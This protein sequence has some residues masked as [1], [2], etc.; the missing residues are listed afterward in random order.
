MP[1]RSAKQIPL[2]AIIIA[3]LLGNLMMIRYWWGHNS[4]GGIILDSYSRGYFAFLILTIIAIVAWGILLIWHKQILAFTAKPTVQRVLFSLIVLSG[5]GIIV[6]S[7]QGFLAS[8]TEFLGMNWGFFALVLLYTHE[9]NP[10]HQGYILGFILL[11]V[12]LIS[13]PII[14]M[15][16]IGRPFS[17]DEAIWADFA[18]SY[19]REGAL[20]YTMA[21][22]LPYII[23]PGVG[24]I[25]ALHGEL[26]WFFDFDIRVS[27]VFQLAIYVLGILS[28]G[29][30]S[31]QLYGKWAGI[32]VMVMAIV[33]SPFLLVFDYRPDHFLILPQALAFFCAVSA[34]QSTD[35]RQG[36]LWNFLAGLL[37]TLSLQF[38]AAGLAYAIGM[39][40]FY[41]AEFVLSTIREKRIT[42]DSLQTLI[43]YGIGAGIGTLI[44]YFANILPVGGLDVYLSALIDDRFTTQRGFNYLF[45]SS[46]LDTVLLWSSLLF[47][48][49]R[50]NSDD[51]RYL[52]LLAFTV[53]GIY[54]IDTQGYVYPYLALFLVPMS[55][56]ISNGFPKRKVWLLAVLVVALIPQTLNWADWRL[57]NQVFRTQSIAPHSI[58]LVGREILARV[59]LDDDTVIV[60]THELVWVMP[61]NQ[62]LHAIASE[63]AMPK[64]MD[65]TPLGVWEL[66]QPEIYIEIPTRA[67]TPEG[68]STYLEQEGFIV[69]Q[70]FSPAGID[71][72]IHR[73]ECPIENTE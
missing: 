52:T 31:K 15:T 68:L 13:I 25:H 58:E 45:R 39:S 11:S 21:N 69:C 38:H 40:L 28:L 3:G 70:E 53:L 65:I 43:A 4:T 23:T 29:L 55:A 35:K 41:L 24:W 37:I 18:A 14:L 72:I 57:L 20:S 7:G 9:D 62:S 64:H 30:L 32:A 63:G 1:D 42:S 22:N 26:Q 36:L 6:A 71:V 51:R 2:L 50:H 73:I 49:W 54:L 5:M 34:W 16:L 48:L 56:L 47:L 44:Y 33:G 59:P 10:K 8:I 46:Q 60:G 19:R 66:L 67:V 27:R 12:I 17:P 61:D